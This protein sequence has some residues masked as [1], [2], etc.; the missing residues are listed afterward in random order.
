MVSISSNLNV[1]LPAVS[2]FTVINRC[3]LLNARSLKNKLCEFNSLLSDNY[4]AVSVTESWLDSS[5]TEGMIDTSG[6]YSLH[7]NDRLTRQGG[8][9][10]CLVSK[11]WPSYTVPIP[12]KFKTLD[13]IAVTILTDV[14][15]LRYITVYRPPEF[16]KLGRDYMVLLVECLEYLCDARHYCTGR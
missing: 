4:M 14:G 15:S 9:V 5:V 6:K 3:V 2:V 8:G 16:N 11:N 13:I 12:E 7:S 10:L 1:N